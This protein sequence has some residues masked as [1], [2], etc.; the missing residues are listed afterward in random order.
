MGKFY[1]SLVASAGLLL[2]LVGSAGA[3][4]GRTLQAPGQAFTPPGFNHVPTTTAL[5]HGWTQDTP[6]SPLRPPGYSNG[7]S[8]WND[9]LGVPPGLSK[10]PQGLTNC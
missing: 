6:T 2:A 8:H 3:G 7:S 5:D 1:L 10:C 4:G 9:S